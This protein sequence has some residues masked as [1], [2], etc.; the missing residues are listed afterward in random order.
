MCFQTFSVVSDAFDGVAPADVFAAFLVDGVVAGDMVGLMMMV[1]PPGGGLLRGAAVSIDISV[2]RFGS[3]WFWGGNRWNSDW[4]FEFDSRLFTA[5]KDYLR[6]LG[7]SFGAVA[8]GPVLC[9]ELG[10]CRIG[11]F[12]LGGAVRL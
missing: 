5:P 12:C 1:D 9:F 8:L 10:I 6:F 3:A 4:K 7:Q 11:D 2:C